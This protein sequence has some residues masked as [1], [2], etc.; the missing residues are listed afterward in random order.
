M[1]ADSRGR[2]SEKTGTQR[3]F[4]PIGCK[5]ESSQVDYMVSPRPYNFAV[6][7]PLKRA[8]ALLVTYD[9]HSYTL[10]H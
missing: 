9:Y 1:P 5:M 7:R 10:G 8:A 4:L 2:L 6:A 3:K